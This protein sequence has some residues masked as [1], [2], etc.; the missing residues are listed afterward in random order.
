MTCKKVGQGEK[1]LYSNEDQNGKKREN[2][3]DNE[4]I[5]KCV[6]VKVGPTWSEGTDVPLP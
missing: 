3:F 2:I 5:F 1:N 6:Y 4:N